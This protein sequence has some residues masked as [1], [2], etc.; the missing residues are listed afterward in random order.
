MVAL[1]TV[2]VEGYVCVVSNEIHAVDGVAIGA[3]EAT[4]VVWENLVEE[5]LYWRT[6]LHLRTCLCKISYSLP[7]RRQVL[8]RWVG[9]GKHIGYHH[10]KLDRLL[11]HHCMLFL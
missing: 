11:Y 4:A 8:S 1:D 3:G 5:K 9:F 10:S 6:K 2:S 7:R